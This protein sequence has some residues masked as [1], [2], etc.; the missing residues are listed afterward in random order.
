MLSAARKTPLFPILANN[1]FY[2][3]PETTFFGGIYCLII[4]SQRAWEYCGVIMRKNIPIGWSHVYMLVED[5]DLFGG[6]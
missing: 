5:K 3:I 4:L 1:K 2:S 6:M